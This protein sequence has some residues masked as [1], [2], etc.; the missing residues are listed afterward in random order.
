MSSIRSVTVPVLAAVLALFSLG[1]SASGPVAEPGEA[2]LI[3]YRAGEFVR[4]E[5][6]KVDVRLGT[7]KLG[8]LEREEAI[9]TS[10]P[11][12]TYVISTGIAGAETI[13]VDLKPGH[14]H[15]VRIGLRERSHN[16]HVSMVEVEEQVA[17]VERPEI[18]KAI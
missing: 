5:R 1:A 6:L 3:V 9:A 11:A 8:R 18:E 16:L 17:R 13:E 4:T 15:Y 7:E 12:G 10:Q 14:A 2:T